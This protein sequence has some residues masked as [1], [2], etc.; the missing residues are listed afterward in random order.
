MISAECRGPL[1][2]AG[3]RWGLRKVFMGQPEQYV[4]KIPEPELRDA[5]VDGRPQRQSVMVAVDVP[6]ARVP[7]RGGG[8]LTRIGGRE[9][10]GAL[11]VPA[12]SEDEERT[13]RDRA[14]QLGRLI[15]ELTGEKPNYLSGSHAFVVNANGHE[16]RAL[17]D[18]PLV[19]Q[20]RLNRRLR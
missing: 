19:R 14:D 1:P 13:A 8:N 20:I 15:Q 10:G 7:L 17:A 11:A 5:V 4:G 3:A 6:V 9:F 12:R 2:A 16:L 18:S